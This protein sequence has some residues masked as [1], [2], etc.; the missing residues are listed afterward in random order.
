MSWCHRCQ[1]EYVLLV[2]ES[3]HEWFVVL[4]RVRPGITFC[5]VVYWEMPLSSYHPLDETY[6]RTYIHTYVCA[7]IMEGPLNIEGAAIN[8]SVKKVA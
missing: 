6:I 3:P 7:W 1:P 2:T 8:Q 5:L 4:D